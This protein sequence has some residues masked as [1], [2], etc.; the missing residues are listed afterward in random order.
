MNLVRI[1]YTGTKYYRDKTELR[2]E[3]TPGDT[4][5]LPEEVARK[6]L[7]FAEFSVA[8]EAAVKAGSKKEAD[9]ITDHERAEVLMK[10]QAAKARQEQEINEREAILLSVQSWDKDQCEAYARKYEVELD[11]R[12]KLPALR[13]EV[14]TLIEQF[15]VR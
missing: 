12:R 10:A 8:A 15:G 11:K 4:K 1:T 14:S 7:R 13:E 2:T 9:D 3:W 5:L 6:L